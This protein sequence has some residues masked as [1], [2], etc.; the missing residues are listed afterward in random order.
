[1]TASVPEP[2]VVIGGGAGLAGA[3][4]PKRKSVTLPACVAVPKGSSE[5]LAIAIPVLNPLWLVTNGNNRLQVHLLT[6]NALRGVELSQK[7]G[8][9]ALESAVWMLASGPPAGA[10]LTFAMA[11]P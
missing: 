1:M 4:P 6:V 2:V 5:V 7:R 10:K 3:T 11:V 9:G 8:I